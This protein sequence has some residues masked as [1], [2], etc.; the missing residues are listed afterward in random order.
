MGTDTT[1]NPQDFRR[2]I[3]LLRFFAES[4]K[5]GILD[6]IGLALST[7]AVREAIYEA[8]RTVK[9]LQL[10]RATFTIK[11]RED[12]TI[13]VNCCDYDKL[14]G[15]CLG[16]LCGIAEAIEGPPEVLKLQKKRVWCAICPE[17]PDEKELSKFFEVLEDPIRGLYLAQITAALALG[18]RSTRL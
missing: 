8:L 3:S 2:I 13:T 18:R 7:S 11:I 6:R 16:G 15:P 12:K 14:E 5:L 10:R 9:A 4:R 17:V 1:L